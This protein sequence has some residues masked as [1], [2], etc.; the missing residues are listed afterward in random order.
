MVSQNEVLTK[1][2]AN[3][4]G[5]RQNRGYQADVLVYGDVTISFSAMEVRRGGQL[6]ALTRK[7]F[8]TLPISSTMHEECSLEM[9][10]STKCGDT[11]FIRLLARSTTTFCSCARTWSQ[12]R[13]A[14]NTF[15]RCGVWD[16]SSWRRESH[17]RRLSKYP[18]RHRSAEFQRNLRTC[19]RVSAVTDASN[20]K[21]REAV[22]KP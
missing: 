15:E 21:L 4:A 11:S 22:Y 18:T 14:P 20:S 13:P 19:F 1:D 8:K 10:F 7:E 17:A 9:N 2:Q 3:I 6:V 16:I 5:Y 12:N